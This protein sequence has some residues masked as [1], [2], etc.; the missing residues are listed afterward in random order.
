M[1]SK[2]KKRTNEATTSEVTTVETNKVTAKETS[3]VT[4][5]DLNN[6]FKR[7]NKELSHRGTNRR[8]RGE[9]GGGI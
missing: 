2:R 9:R 3:E 4:T 8:K 5:G 1:K 7:K 6:G